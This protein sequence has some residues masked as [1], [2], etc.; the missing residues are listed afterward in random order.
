M[1]AVPGSWQ[2]AAIGSGDPQIVPRAQ[3]LLKGLP[4]Q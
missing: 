3:D 2:E 1:P 4:G